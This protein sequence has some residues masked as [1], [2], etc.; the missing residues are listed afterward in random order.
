MIFTHETVMKQ[1]ACLHLNL[2]P[3]ALCVDGTLGGCGHARAILDAIAP[4]GK[5]IGIDQDPDAIAHAREV[6]QPFANRTTLVHDNFAY[7]PRILKQMGINAVDAVFVDL[8]LSFHQLMESKRGFSFTKNELLDMRMDP[9]TEVTAGEMLN[10]FTEQKLA[11]IFFR[12]G[13]ERLSRKIAGAIVQKR[14]ESPLLTTGELAQLISG[15]M[16]ARLVRTQKIHPA[17]RV[18][19]ALRIAVNREMEKLE[20]FMDHAPELLNIGGRIC[21][22]S[23]HSLEDRIVKRAIRSREKGQ[24]CTCPR[25]FPQCTCGFTPSLKSITKGPITPTAEEIG[26]N[27]LSRSAKL[28]VAEKISFDRYH[29]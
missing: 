14:Q 8:G 26:K 7:L 6:L 5:L 22:I 4:E 2:K 20:M 3:G 25:D 28:R 18:F 21:V 19:Q 16:P 12:Y 10:T 29:D 23:F 17:T 11:D 13:E 15:V 24:G 1:E 27:P 9:R